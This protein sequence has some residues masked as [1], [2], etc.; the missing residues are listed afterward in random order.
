MIVRKIWFDR[1]CH[2]R[3]ANKVVEMTGWFLFGFIP[4]YI[5]EVRTIG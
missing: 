1:T 4:I 5:I 2:K 3:H